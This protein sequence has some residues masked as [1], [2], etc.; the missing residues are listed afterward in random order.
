VMVAYR[1]RVIALTK[2]QG[3]TFG[4][5]LRVEQGKAGHLVRSLDM[6][7]PAKLAGMKDGDHILRVNGN[8]VVVDLVKENGVSV[9]FHVIDEVSYNRSKAE[10]YDLSE[11]HPRPVTNGVGGQTRKA[12]LLSGQVNRKLRILPPWG[13]VGYGAQGDPVP[14]FVSPLAAWSRSLMALSGTPPLG[15]SPAPAP[16]PS[17]APAP[18][19]S[20][21]PAPGSSAA[22][23]S[24]GSSA[25]APP[26]PGSSAAA[27]PSPGSSAATPPP[28]GSSA[29]AATPPPDRLLLLQR[30]HRPDRLLLLQRHRRPDRLL[31]QQRHRPGRLLQ[32]HRRPD[33]LLL[34]QRHRPG[35]L[36]QRHRRPV[37]CCSNA[38]AARVVCCCCN[39]T[40]ARIVCCCCN[41]TA[42][43]IQI[44]S[45]DTD[46]PACSPMLFWEERESSA[47]PP[48]YTEAI[49]LPAPGHS[50][51]TAVR[52]EKEEHDELKPKLCRMQKNPEGYGF[53]LNG[54]QGLCGQHIKQVVR[55]GV[56]HRAGLEDG[57]IVVEV[58]SV[59]V[60]NS[61]HEQVV[62]LIRRSGS[63]LE[64]LVARKSM[65]DKLKAKG[66]AVTAMLLGPR[67]AAQVHTTA[68]VEERPAV[69]TRERHCFLLLKIVAF[70]DKGSRGIAITW[71]RPQ[72]TVRPVKS[73]FR[74]FWVASSLCTIAMS[75]S[76]AAI[77][78]QWLFSADS[79]ETT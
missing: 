59:N 41:A 79:R 26:S 43:R 46:C 12:K 25:A 24:P 67:S 44:P 75:R 56:A 70:D 16:G 5:M 68:M 34:L 73:S 29:A 76:N 74:A 49:H 18:G 30:H 11:P 22:P 61:T 51:A 42:A 21:A 66:V 32:R 63:S 28:P 38:T 65:Y 55:G 6:G 78:S 45:D 47:S 23:P 9:T 72:R 27:P 15:P 20:A 8:F 10:A 4:F 52:G 53:H 17:P 37:V 35:R 3:H 39:A 36:L 33:R 7:G 77:E 50:A 14:W 64:L 69:Q 54:I 19:S 40:A 48:S 62:D 1:Q 60:E 2:R 57:D 31:L 13:H 58:N 71:P